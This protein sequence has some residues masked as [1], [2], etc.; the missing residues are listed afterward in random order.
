MVGAEDNVARGTGTPVTAAQDLAAKL[1]NSRLVE[2]PGVRHMLF[3]ERPEVV[4]PEVE[5][6]LKEC[7]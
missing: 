4:W 6:F 5:R 3:W 7:P 1:P 2:I